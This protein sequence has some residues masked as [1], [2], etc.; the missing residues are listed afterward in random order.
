M[1][2]RTRLTALG[3]AAVLAGAL[4]AAAPLTAMAAKRAVRRVSASSTVTVV[5]RA[6]TD[7]TVYVGG[8]KKDVTGNLLTFHNQ[9]YNPS[10]T[11]MVGSDLGVCVRVKTATP[12]VTPPEGSYHCEWTNILARGQITVSGPFYD[13]KN[14]VLSII[15][16][17]GAY[18]TARGQMNLISRKGGTEYDFVFHLAS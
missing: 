4:A 3:A 11:R 15:G 5:E 14:S 2:T 12:G 6:V 9:L 8:D 10:D 1:S 13:S 7:T 18:R 16:G 17:T